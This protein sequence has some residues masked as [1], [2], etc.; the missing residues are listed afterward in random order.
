MTVP[1]QRDPDLVQIVE[2]GTDDLAA[3]KANVISRWGRVPYLTADPTSPPDGSVWVRSDDGSLRWRSGGVTSPTAW[4][5]VTF[6]NSWVNFGGTSQVARYRKIGDQVYIEGRIKTGT[7]AVVAFT[8]PAGFRPPLVMSFST[9]SVSLFGFFF[10]DQ[11]GGVTPQVGT[12][13]DFWVVCN[14]S[15]V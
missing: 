10:I 6:Q 11:A 14:F 7:M 3:L 5:G 4:T 15:T 2:K 12:N 8:L 1:N 9:V 13:T